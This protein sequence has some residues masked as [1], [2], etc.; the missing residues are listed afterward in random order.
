MIRFVHSNKN[1]MLF[2]SIILLLA[3]LFLQ[4]CTAADREG[5]TQLSGTASAS[6]SKSKTLDP[7]E[8]EEYKVFVGAKVVFNQSNHYKFMGFHQG[9]IVL[10][11][12]SWSKPVI[13][14]FPTEVG[15]LL[16]DTEN[17]YIYQLMSYEPKESF[18]II[19]RVR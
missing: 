17:S 18:I 5:M 15:T 19:K 14:Y 6:V 9:S 10:Q 2:A 1:Q 8:Q 12:V 7:V 11:D 3:V 4:G 16:M 13:L